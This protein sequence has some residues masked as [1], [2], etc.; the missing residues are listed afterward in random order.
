M[1]DFGTNFELI[2]DTYI[3]YLL[4]EVNKV[5]YLFRTNNSNIYNIILYAQ[6]QWQRQILV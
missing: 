4:R 2:K 3:L 1:V 6:P 5:M